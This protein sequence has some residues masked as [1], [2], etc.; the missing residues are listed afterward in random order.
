MITLHLRK[1]RSRSPLR[2]GLFSIAFAICCFALSQTAQAVL[3]SPTPDGGYP[4][5][6]TAEGQGALQSL[7]IGVANTAIGCQTLLNN[8]EGRF[9]TATGAGALSNNIDADY[10]TASGCEALFHNTSGFENT[11][12]GFQ[13]LYMN[14]HGIFNTA[15]G[16]QALYHNDSG[17][18]TA[19]GRQALYGNTTGGYNT[20][21]GYEALF[22][23]TGGYQN[24]AYGME[25]LYSNTTGVDNT[26]T[27][28]QTLFSNTTGLSNAAHGFQ[29]LFFNTSGRNN[30]ADGVY[31]LISNTSG[32]NNTATGLGALDRNTVGHDN[33]ADGYQA[34]YYNTT[35]SYNVALAGGSNLTTGDYNI[36]I[37][38]QGV[39]AEANTIRIGDSNQSATFIAGIAGATVTGSAVFIDITTGQLG[40]TSSSERFKDGI[41]SMGKASEALLSLRPV[42]FHYK[43][44]IDPNGAPQF[45][46]VAEEVEKVNPD[47]VVRDAQGKVFTV[48][49]EAVNAMLLN[50][51]LK[52]H[53][54]VEE[55]EKDLRATI[56]QQQKEIKALTASL[57]EQASQI[58][59]VSAQFQVSK[60]APQI[61]GND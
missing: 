31:A 60:S 57:K 58:Q 55:L 40:L 27:G 49:Y 29:A 18:N 22:Y 3:P 9:N 17:Y 47:L 52:E 51:F 16:S 32:S 50:E 56:V 41:E 35:G 28:M 23:N 1:P 24:T 11:A 25:A 21:T 42:T 7:T 43:K 53:R 15:T 20:A 39:A 54:K 30:T 4:G 59:K 14:T 61:A 34:L 19:T 6:N 45:G 5:K 37:G 48:R 46:L 33:V 26:A 38:N 44:N 8:M 36:D 13:A 2:R 12:I 10:N